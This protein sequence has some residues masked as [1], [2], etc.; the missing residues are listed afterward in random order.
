MDPILQERYY[1]AFNLQRD[2]LAYIATKLEEWATERGG[3]AALNE[4]E[5]NIYNARYAGFI[6]LAM[7]SDASREYVESLELWI[8]DLIT[9]VRQLRAQNKREKQP[10]S[11]LTES[12]RNYYDNQRDAS[13][14]RAQMTWP[15][16]Y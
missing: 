13:I 4:T 3:K 6:K 8:T 12:G 5:R 10:W 11:Q 15:E 1:Q 16:L 2:Q 14:M 7:Y 9:E